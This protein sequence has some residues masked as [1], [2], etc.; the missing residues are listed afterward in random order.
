MLGHFYPAFA[1]QL[2]PL[3]DVFISMIKLLVAPIIFVTVVV[4]LADHAQDG[5]TSW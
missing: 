5:P 3:G 4:G 1:V 2:K